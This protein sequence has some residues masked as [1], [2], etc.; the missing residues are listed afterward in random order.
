MHEVI[1]Q[2]RDVVVPLAQRR[3]L[4]VKYVE[5]VEKIGPKFALLD[6]LLE[7]LVGGGDATEIYF[8]G[9]V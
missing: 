9:L 5:P 6:Q 7:I 4:D 3:E 2:E 1:Y 8:D